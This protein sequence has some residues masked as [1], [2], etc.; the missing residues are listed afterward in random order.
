MYHLCDFFDLL[1]WCCVLII[2]PLKNSQGSWAWWGTPLIPAQ[3]EAGEFLSSRP[4]WSS[5]WVPGQPGLYRETL[6]WKKTK[7]NKQTNKQKEFSR[8][9]YAVRP[10][11]LFLISA[12]SAFY[13]FICCLID[14][15]ITVD[16]CKNPST[17]TTWGESFLCLSVFSHTILLSIAWHAV[18]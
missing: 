6:S 11:S 8:G 17:H 12:F 15:L 10:W 2:L 16:L 18:K 5:K 14:L 7:T 3:A 9:S 13:L 4:A 1:K